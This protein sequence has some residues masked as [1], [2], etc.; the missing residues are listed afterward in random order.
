[1]NEESDRILAERT[2]EA[3]KPKV[4]TKFIKGDAGSLANGVIQPG[5]VRA[6]DAFH[7]FIVSA[8]ELYYWGGTNQRSERHWSK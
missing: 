4:G 3:M 1:M 5:T 2:I 7:N 8:C 6:Q